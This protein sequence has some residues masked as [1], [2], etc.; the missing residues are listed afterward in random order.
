MRKRSEAALSN[1]VDKA[2]AA[3]PQRSIACA[4]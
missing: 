3:I 1:S 2:R 4:K